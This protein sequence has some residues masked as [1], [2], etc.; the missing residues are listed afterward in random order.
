MLTTAAMGQ[1][2]QCLK[3]KIAT[4]E[5]ECGGVW[6]AAELD[7]NIAA[8]SEHRVAATVSIDGE[9][10]EGQTVTAVRLIDANG[11]VLA[12]NAVAITRETNDGV[13]YRF[14]I[15]LTESEA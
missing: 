7:V 8:S 4:A 2:T 9:T 1:L 13:L 5:F 14:D 6:Y 3:D 15:T 10:A 12:E 11:D